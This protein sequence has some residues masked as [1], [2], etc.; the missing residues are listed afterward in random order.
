MNEKTIQDEEDEPMIRPPRS[1]YSFYNQEPKETDS[2]SKK[3]GNKLI[4][5]RNLSSDRNLPYADG[6]NHDILGEQFD[7]PTFL[8][9]NYPQSADGKVSRDSLKLNSKKDFP[10]KGTSKKKI[11]FKKKRRKNK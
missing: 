2:E 9:R 1:A 10:K 5:I 7:T 11:L 6:S 4:P 3:T 8:R